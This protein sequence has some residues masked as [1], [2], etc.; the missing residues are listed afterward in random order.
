MQFI[1]TCEKPPPDRVVNNKLKD[2]LKEIITDNIGTNMILNEK[3]ADSLFF[4]N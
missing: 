3:S 1:S 4:F 2:E